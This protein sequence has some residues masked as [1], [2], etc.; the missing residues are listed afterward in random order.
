MLPPAPGAPRE[1]A[2][3]PAA[4]TMP[5]VGAANTYSSAAMSPLVSPLS[6]GTITGDAAQSPLALTSVVAPQ[7]GNKPLLY[8]LA[9]ASVSIRGQAAPLLYVSPARI[10]FLVP[11]GVPQGEWEVIVTSQ[12]GYVSRGTVVVN[13]VVPALFTAD[14]S[15]AGQALSMNGSEPAVVFYDVNSPHAFGTDKRTRV[16]LF[17][18]GI[19]AGAPNTNPANDV[20]MENGGILANVAES[21]T[22]EARTRDGRVYN[23][24]VE[25]AGALE[26][27]M[28][29]LDQINVVLYSELRGAGLVDL[30]VIINGQRSNT[31]AINVK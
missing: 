11:Q 14:G 24:P 5:Y 21:L 28:L 4:D 13:A 1:S 17:A 25:F 2:H 16:T 20:R 23:L 15:G 12:D 7:G 19:G 6:L 31:A 26:G 10:S 18:T 3:A 9:G 29:G 22:V 8:E 30:T 27:R